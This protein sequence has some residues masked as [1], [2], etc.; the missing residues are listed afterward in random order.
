MRHS[1]GKLPRC[2]TISARQSFISS[3]FSTS[4]GGGGGRG[5]GGG[6]FGSDNSPIFGFT[7]NNDAKDDKSAAAP[8]PP[9]GIGH[10]RGSGKPFPSSFSSSDQFVAGNASAATP[11]GHGR[12]V[13][14]PISVPSPSQQRMSLQQPQHKFFVAGEESSD[15]QTKASADSSLP[16]SI[17]SVLSGAGRGKPTVTPPVSEKPKEENRHLRAR[18]TPQAE[19]S[20]LPSPRLSREE[21]VKKAVGILSRGDDDGGRGRGAMAPRGGRGFSG[22]GREGRGRGGGGGRGR[23]RM[24]RGEG[25][26]QDSGDE[27]GD[28]FEVGDDAAAE[29]LA[30]EVGPEIANQLAEG[31]EEM[32]PRVFPSLIED[33][34]LDALDTNLKIECEEEYMMGEFDMNPDIDEKPPI[35]LRDALEKMKPFLMVYEGIES[36]EEW[37]EVMK[38]TMEVRLPIIKEIVDHYSGPDRVTAKQQHEE[39]NRVAATLPQRAPT[40]VKLFTERAVQSLQSNPSWGFHKKCQFMDKLVYEVSQQ[41]K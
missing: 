4:T 19:S 24:G 2:C 15:S 8:Q 18:K 40:S 12:G 26:Q 25:I 13:P 21:A 32:G 37:E 14:L 38:E 22:G 9:S 39:L 36:Q 27:Y 7:P 35:P 16:S 41:Y 11:A 33:A 3:A 28:V 23:G 17:L 34:Y 6:G 20:K 10:G 29:K 5:R 31:I 1:W 30:Q